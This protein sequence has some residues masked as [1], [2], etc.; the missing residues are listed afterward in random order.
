MRFLQFQSYRCS[1]S[2]DLLK[3]APRL[4][5]VLIGFGVTGPMTSISFIGSRRPVIVPAT[6]TS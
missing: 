1:D 3:I 4:L 5:G 6:R 2:Y